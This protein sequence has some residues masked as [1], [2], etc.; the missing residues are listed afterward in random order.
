MTADFPF[1][2][3][4]PATSLSALAASLAPARLMRSALMESIIDGASKRRLRSAASLPAANCSTSCT[5]NSSMSTNSPER[6][7]SMSVRRPPTTTT[8]ARTTRT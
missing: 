7:T 5:T 1:W 8:S 4:A 3:D 2:T 6:L